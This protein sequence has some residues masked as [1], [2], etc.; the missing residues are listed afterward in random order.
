MSYIYV[1]CTILLTVYGQLII[2]WQVLR[3]GSLPE[4]C[5]AENLISGASAAQPMATESTIMCNTH[6]IRVLE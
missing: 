2:K 1:L 4:V 6:P 5:A 3:A